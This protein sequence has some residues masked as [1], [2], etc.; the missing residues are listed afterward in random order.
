MLKSLLTLSL[1]ALAAHAQSQSPFQHTGELL[2][3][4]RQDRPADISVLNSFGITP[5][6]STSWLPVQLLRPALGVDLFKLRDSMLKS[7]AFEYVVFNTVETEPEE[8][9]ATSLDLNNQWHHDAIQSAE[10]WDYQVGSGNVV[11][12]VCDSGI[13]ANHEDLQGRVL[14]GWNLVGN[15]SEATT[16][17]NHGT[18]VAGL[19]GATLNEVGVA[20]VAP[21][22]KL[23][24]LRISDTNGSTNMKRITDCIMLAADRGAKVVNV[25]FTGVES[26]AVAAAGKYAHQ[27][28]TLVVY[29]A[30]NHGKLRSET[31]YP[32]SPFVV[33]V[34]GTNKTDKRWTW[35]KFLRSGGSNYGAFVDIS[36]PGL[37]LTSTAVYNVTNPQAV[38]YRTGSGTS[39]S[40]PIVSGVAALIYSVNPRFTPQDVENILLESADKIGVS[41][42]GAGRVN[43]LKAVRLAIQ[44][45]Q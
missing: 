29:S 4:L 43:A 45:A 30:G 44:R 31:S 27:K 1:L 35:R 24:P 19:I 40:A 42:L 15:N 3:K 21:N 2:Y 16:S 23:L 5:S 20:G 14:P 39:Y 13:Q 10:S 28:G 17:T 9:E 12:A 22:I 34:G 8:E 6:R 33:A 25:S 26:A 37:D 7:Q 38:K 36:A 32:K 18:H 41:G 11:V